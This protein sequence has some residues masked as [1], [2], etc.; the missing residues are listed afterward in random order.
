MYL[1]FADAKDKLSGAFAFHGEAKKG[2]WGVLGD[3]LFIRLSTEVSYTAGSIG[4]AIDGALE[5]DQTMFNAKALYRVRPDGPLYVVGGVRTV[6]MSPN[7]TFTGPLGA[8]LGAIDVSRTSAAAV[9]GAIFRP[10]LGSRAVLATWR[11]GCLRPIF[12]DVKQVPK[13]RRRR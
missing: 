5:L 3:L 7:A 2:R 13:Y 1:D 12:R 4:V 11:A 9:G 8:Q 10:K 6:T